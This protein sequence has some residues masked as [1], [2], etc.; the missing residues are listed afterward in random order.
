MV[1]L[2]IENSKLIMILLLIGTI[3]ELAYFGNRP[4]RPGTR[5]GCPVHNAKRTEQKR[6][7]RSGAR[8]FFSF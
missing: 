4:Y 1:A 5:E 6:P 2:L 8:L 7:R 3:I